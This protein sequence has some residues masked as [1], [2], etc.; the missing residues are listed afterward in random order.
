MKSYIAVSC[1]LITARFQND[2]VMI[3][4]SKLFLHHLS[5]FQENFR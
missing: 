5:W 2:I 4:S 3:L 1:A